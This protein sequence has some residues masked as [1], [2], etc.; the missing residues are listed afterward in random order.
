[1]CLIRF[2]GLL[3]LNLETVTT[4]YLI[5]FDMTYQGVVRKQMERF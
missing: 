4:Y 5:Q 2:H 3:I 1:M